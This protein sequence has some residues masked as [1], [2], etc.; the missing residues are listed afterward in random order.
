[1]PTCNYHLGAIQV[2]GNAVGGGGVVEGVRFSLKKK[3][4]EDV[5]YNV[6]ISVSRGWVLNFQKKSVS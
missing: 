3:R 5:P 1:M 4:Y 6:V 2:L